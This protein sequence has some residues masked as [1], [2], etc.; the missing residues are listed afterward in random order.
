MVQGFAV[1]GR[2]IPYRAFGGGHV[3]RGQA[4]GLVPFGTRF[5]LCSTLISVHSKTLLNTSLFRS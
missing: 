5:Q 2:Q 1:P 3:S 4:S